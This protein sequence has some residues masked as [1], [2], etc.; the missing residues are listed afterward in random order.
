M[1]GARFGIAG[2]ALAGAASLLFGK[3]ALEALKSKGPIVERDGYLVP[4]SA[5]AF[6]ERLHRSNQLEI[7]I[8]R[9]AIERGVHARVRELGEYLLGQHEKSDYELMETCNRLGIRL[10]KPIPATPTELATVA[11]QVAAEHKLQALHGL[12]FDH[13]YAAF[14]LDAHDHAIGMLRL[15]ADV[16]SDGELGDLCKAQV[17]ALFLHRRKIVE[18]CEEISPALEVPAMKPGQAPVLAD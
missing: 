1:R 16:F 14:M 18:L 7:Q 17:G 9:Q 3:R 12:A 13:A 6:C 4:K 2:A 15:G 11:S 10:G 5:K 8:N